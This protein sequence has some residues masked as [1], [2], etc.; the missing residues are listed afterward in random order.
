M[1]NEIKNKGNNKLGAARFIRNN[2]FKKIWKKKAS[3]VRGK[4]C[5]KKR[6]ILLFFKNF[7]IVNVFEKNFCNRPDW[8]TSQDEF[9][10][11]V[12]CLRQKFDKI[13]AVFLLKNVKLQ[14]AFGLIKLRIWRAESYNVH[15]LFKYAR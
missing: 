9:N 8:M 2:L 14:R 5:L 12:D 15:L 10:S 1:T 4:I 11:K 7:T 3:R 6:K 13:K